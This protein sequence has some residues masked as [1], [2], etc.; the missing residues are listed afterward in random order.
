MAA[1]PAVPRDPPDSSG[2]ARRPPTHIRS[3]RSSKS[4]RR[5]A[6]RPFVDPRWVRPRSLAGRRPVQQGP[7]GRTPSERVPVDDGFVT[8][9]DRQASETSGSAI[10]CHGRSHPPRPLCSQSDTTNTAP[11]RSNK[12]APAAPAVGRHETHGHSSQPS[13]DRPRSVNDG[14][15]AHEIPAPIA[16]A[17]LD[18]R[19]P[20]S[21]P[22]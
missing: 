16:V 1:G 9:D 12:G 6:V 8:A 20:M 3:N 2:P 19:I 21:S 14:G 7:D 5:R 11:F 15:E 17:L 4:S 18:T 13:R 10:Q 22:P